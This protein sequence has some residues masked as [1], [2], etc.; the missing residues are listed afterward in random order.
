MEPSDSSHRPKH[1]RSSASVAGFRPEI[2]TGQDH[3]SSR[4]AGGKQAANT[5]QPGGTSRHTT[6]ANAKVRGAIEALRLVT[7]WRCLRSHGSGH[8]FETC[9]AHHRFC[10]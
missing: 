6:T 3:T 5:L 7:K 9:H 4:P 8:R 1:R 2:V 10:S